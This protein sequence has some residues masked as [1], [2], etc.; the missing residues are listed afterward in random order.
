MFSR[1]AGLAFLTATALVA[2]AGS[3][4]AAGQLHAGAPPQILGVVATLEAVPMQCDN[5]TCRADLTAFCLEPHR[6]SPPRGQSYS[7]VDPSALTLVIGDEAGET[8]EVTGDG[9]LRFEAVRG[10]TA[11]R[12]S[13]DRSALAE[14]GAT[15][16][17][18]QVGRL[19]SVLPDEGADDPLRHTDEEIARATG[20]LR[21]LADGIVDRGG[22][23]AD[24]VRQVARLVNSLPEAGRLAPAARD[25]IWR[26]TLGGAPNPLDGDPGRA[27]TSEAWEDCAWRVGQA[28]APNMRGCLESRHDRMISGPTVDYWDAA[29]P[30]M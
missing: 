4:S 24:T 30:G 2:G 9:R 5:M 26:D 29:Q 10:Y 25:D 16:A 21:L 18:I 6:P 1:L 23:A 7:A 3:A 28:M 12:V 27:G 14:M 17:A 22:I 11:V 8:R 13:I 19:V 15:T 20:P